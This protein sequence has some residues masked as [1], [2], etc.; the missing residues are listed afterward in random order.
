MFV[1]LVGCPGSGKS[2]WAQKFSERKLKRGESVCIISSDAIRFELWGDERIQREPTKVFE[3]AHQRIIEAMG[4]GYDYVIFDATNIQRRHR[5]ALMDKIKKFNDEYRCVVFAEPYEELCR[6]NR[7]RAR[8]VPEEVI[9]RMITQFDIPLHSEGYDHIGVVNEKQLDLSEYLDRMRDFNQDNPHHT[10][11]LLDHCFEATNYIYDHQDC[12]DRFSLAARAAFIH[13]I[14]KPFVKTY[15]NAKGE[16]SEYAHYYGHEKVG[17]YLTLMFNTAWSPAEK[18]A[19]A[20]LVCYHMI[21]YTFKTEAARRRWE[22][23]LGSIY[24]AIMLIHEADE[25]AH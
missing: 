6:R 21:P 20:Q 5:V 12:K 13:D 3:L 24:D 11:D 22:E 8:S 14:G 25:S 9:W 18:L 17:G 10:R 7:Q 2:T 1:M 16:P 15:T 23:R 4:A 19:I